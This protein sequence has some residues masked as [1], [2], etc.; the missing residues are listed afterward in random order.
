MLRVRYCISRY[1]M[2]CGLASTWA[3]TPPQR[4]SRAMNSCRSPSLRHNPDCCWSAIGSA[5]VFAGRNYATALSHLDRAVELY[6][7]EEHGSLRSD[8]AQTSALPLSALG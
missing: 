2:G 8:L 5:L 1:C 7:P 3:A 6:R 4:S